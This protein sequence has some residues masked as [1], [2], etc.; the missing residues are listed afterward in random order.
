MP[1]ESLSEVDEFT[2]ASG[3][4]LSRFLADNARGKRV[5]LCPVGGRTALNYGYASPVEGRM[6]ST[7]GLSDVGDYPARDMT[8]TVGAGIR[9]EKL[10]QILKAEGQQLPIDVA[11]SKRATLGGVVATNTSGPRRYGYGTMR[12]YVIGL[13]AVD[14]SG[15]LFHS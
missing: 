11:Q 13:A 15:R 4:E 12:D 2:P 14:A 3:K 5:P 7:S 9:I 8:I 6:I 1:A 10:Q